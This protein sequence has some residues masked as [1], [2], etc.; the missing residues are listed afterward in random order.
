MVFV[1]RGFGCVEKAFGL[2]CYLGNHDTGLLLHDD[3]TLGFQVYG[4]GYQFCGVII[5]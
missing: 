4:L 3:L 5:T 2:S 1:C